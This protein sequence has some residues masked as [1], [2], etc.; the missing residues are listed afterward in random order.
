[1][2]YEA[3]KTSTM[4]AGTPATS[5]TSAG[6]RINRTKFYVPVVTL[7]IN[8]NIKFLKNRNQGCKRTVSWNKYRS[9]ITTELRNNNLDYIIDPALGISLGCLFFNSKLVKMNLQE[10]LFIF[11]TC[12][13]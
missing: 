5:T 4:A 12:C 6:L 11:I 8:D 9:E 10:I 7:P 1:M 3:S 13:K 2:I